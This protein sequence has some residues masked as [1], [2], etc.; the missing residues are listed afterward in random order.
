MSSILKALKK[1]EAEKSLP[2]NEKEVKV[3]SDILK[4]V[5]V[6]KRSVNWLWPLGI[7]A[8]AAIIILSLALFRKTTTGDETR[9]PL[10]PTTPV[11]STSLPLQLPAVF[12]RP[13]A[14]DGKKNA[15]APPSPLKVL[16]QDSS[17]PV[18]D[19]ERKE[20]RTLTELPNTPVFNVE[21]PKPDL[22]ARS[23]PPLLTALPGDTTLTLSGIAWNKD[24]SDRLA[25]IN[26]QPTVTGAIVNGAVVE[27]ILQDKVRMNLSGRTFELFLGKQ[28][29]TN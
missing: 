29:R 28:T 5:A 24:S 17:R 12:P 22:A 14:V 9:S 15:I 6:R 20:P 8:A 10:M 3:S 11:L 7:S 19:P 18:S 25:I 27:E 16:N 2:K 13:T 21:L 1:L 26:G 23:A 4:P